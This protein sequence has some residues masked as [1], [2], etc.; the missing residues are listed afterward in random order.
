MKKNNIRSFRYS[1]ETACILEQYRGDS[2]N[3]KFEN[4]V[5]DA[6]LMVERKREELARVNERIVQRRQVLKNLEN[7]TAKLALLEGDISRAKSYFDVVQQRAK[8]IADASEK[9]R[10]SECDTDTE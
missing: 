5:E 10:A 6:F 1:D 9:D 3:A 8:E 7:A 4:L 2:L